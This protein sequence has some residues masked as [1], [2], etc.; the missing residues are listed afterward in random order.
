MKLTTLIFNS[1]K[2]SCWQLVSR[3]GLNSMMIIIPIVVALFLLDLMKQGAV[4]HVPIAIVNLDNSP[5]SR[6]LERNLCAMQGVDVTM[7]CASHGEAMMALQ[8]G[9]ILGFFFIPTDL[10]ERTLEGRDPVVSYYI[11]YAYFTPS[12]SQYK[13]F[14]TVSLLANGAIAKTVL[15]ATG[16][17]SERDIAST[18]QPILTHVHGI[19]NPWTNYGYYL[20]LSFIPCFLALIVMLTAV[21]TLGNELK[22]DTSR[23]WLETSGDSIMLAVTSKLL[24]QTA[25][26]TVVGWFIQ[27]IM[28]RVYDM[29]FNGNPWHMI[30][31]MMLLVLACQAFALL[32]FSIVPNYRLAATLCTLLGMLSFS[33]CGFSLP[34]EAMYP[35][36]N[37]I[38]YVMPIRH[39]FLISVD[40]ALNGIDLYY[41]RM[42]YAAL[43]GYTLLPMPLLYRI[44]KECKNPLYLP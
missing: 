34:A 5:M 16:L 13:G 28:F 30:W 22:Y 43:I 41:S 21:T 1:F 25:V 24:P 33:F 15:D 26:F 39:F 2:R 7:H 17:L 32:M 18:L 31:A 37:A 12:S 10:E 29:P 44:K 19:N 38:G 23:E 3:R 40:Q 20:N 6:Q 14:K 36:I 11:N 8:R 27:F 35:W 9:E 4:E 42:H